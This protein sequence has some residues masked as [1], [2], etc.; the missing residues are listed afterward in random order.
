MRIFWLTLGGLSLSVGVVGIVV[1]L[2]PT[3]VFVILAA[4]CFAR[5]SERLHD[6]LISHRYFGLTHD[7]ADVGRLLHP[8]VCRISRVT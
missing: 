8:I 6:W 4:Y 1:P 3:T 7:V 2:L 5:S